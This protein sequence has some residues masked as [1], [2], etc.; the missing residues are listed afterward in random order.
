MGN[1][2]LTVGQF[3]RKGKTGAKPPPTA[4]DQCRSTMGEEEPGRQ[5]GDAGNCQFLPPPETSRFDQRALGRYLGAIGMAY[6]PEQ[7]LQQFAGGFAILVGPN[8]CGKST[9]I[10]A[11]RTLDA[12]VRFARTR[13][14]ARLHIGDESVIGYRIPNESV[15]ISLENVQTDYNGAESRVTFRLSSGNALAL[16]FPDDGGWVSS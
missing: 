11:L 13:P 16:V 7:P 3:Y 14:P 9:I 4:A 15:P 2:C 10:G 8:N 1:D 6:D 5:S 12:A